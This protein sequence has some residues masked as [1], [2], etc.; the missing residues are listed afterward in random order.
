ME[1]WALHERQDDCWAQEV[2]HCHKMLCV[3]MVL[4]QQ[5]DSVVTT[6][7]H[8]HVHPVVAALKVHLHLHLEA[9]EVTFDAH[10]ELA[11]ASI[12]FAEKKRENTQRA[13]NHMNEKRDCNA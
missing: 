12:S 9:V 7:E 8:C 1:L 6:V 2:L 11:T 13:D 10:Q 5:L 3:V 4:K